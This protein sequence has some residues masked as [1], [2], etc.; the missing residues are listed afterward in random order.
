MFAGKAD[1]MTL[2]LRSLL[3]L[4]VLI[5]G[6]AHAADAPAPG[7]DPAID[8]SFMDL[9]ADP[10]GNFFRY[11]C[12]GWI[13]ANPIPA[14]QSSWGLD[15]VL[16]ERNQLQL[17]AILEKAAAAPTPETKKI[18]DFYASCMDEAGIE[19]LGAAPLKP[20]LAKVEALTDK[21]QLPALLG[22]L[23]REGVESLFGF[24]AGQD[25]KD[26]ESE[27]A[28][29]DEGGMGLPDRD[30]YLKT[31]AE[32]VKLRA[33][34]V[35]HVA[36]MFAPAG[37]SE[38]DAAAHAQ[39]VLKIETALAKGA[40]DRV[41]RRD[42]QL[43]YHLL[44]RTELDALTP[45]FD[46]AA[47]F[48]AVGAPPVEKIDITEQKFFNTAAKLVAATS[49]N[50]LK[51]YLKW[52]VITGSAPWLPKAFVDENFAF[53]GK[54]LTGATEIRPRWKRCVSAV[55][56]A[57]GEDLGRAWVADH[58]PPEAKAGTERMVAAITEAF[59]DDLKTID[60][61]SPQTREKALVKLGQMRKK[62]GYP[63]HWRDYGAMT[64]TRGDMLGNAEQADAFEL[65]R[66]LGKIG[67]PV[68]RGEWEMSP[69]TVN[70]YYDPQMN[71]IN[72][73][74]GILQPPFF[75]PKYDDAV[76]FGATAGG[77]VG[78]EMTHGFDDQGRQYD[79]KGNL[80]DWWTKADAAKFK[81]RA[82]CVVDQ[83]SGYVAVDKLHIN[84][85][86]TLGENVADLG[87]V[88]LGY[89]ALMKILKDKP[90]PDIGGF[91]PAQRYFIAYGQSWCDQT[92]PE[93]KRLRIMTDPHSPAEFR[94][95]G[96][97]SDMP[98]FA[99]A[100]SCRPDAPMVRAK[101]CRVW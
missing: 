14:D 4:L 13:D 93:S 59:E 36:K 97:V 77:T 75:S 68:D 35:A 91:S 15:Q 76:N 22:A 42:P 39:T 37:D 45:G 83:Y 63:D 90:S 82:Q 72:M 96:V 18:G 46:W 24:G 58:Y 57:L 98:E 6:T 55:D 54:R 88:R 43:T 71:D 41:S 11:A 2:V 73:P 20:K 31:D 19:A 66:E 40:L 100:F 25:A 99:Q 23:H 89:V 9:K 44:K 81:A 65:Q 5:A 87:G 26:A 95:N 34:Y 17:R 30:Y 7:A 16:M 67:K 78:H 56:E 21:T 85:K 29:A 28:I 62:L 33:D 47:Y 52:H 64:I 12:G 10:C 70:A 51:T 48:S 69:P 50:D 80:T 53:Y 1:L 86:L 94:V 3:V 84:G 38:K 74:A 61:M 92:R 101:A 60:W 32:S 79:G 27:I 8:H 49:L